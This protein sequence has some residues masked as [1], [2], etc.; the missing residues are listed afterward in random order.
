MVDAAAV[1]D[2]AEAV[3]RRDGAGATIAAIAEASG[4]TK[5]IVYDLVG[6]RTALADALVI[7]LTNRLNE[8]A[9][10]AIHSAE[11]G[12][13]SIVAFLLATLEAIDRDRD[14][15]LYVTAPTGDDGPD[16]RLSLARRASAPIAEQLERQRRAAGL[17]PSAATPW[18][19]AITG[20]VNFVSLW[21]ISEQD[22]TAAEVAEQLADLLW[23]GL[24]GP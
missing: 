14:L 13:P 7:R 10:S 8:A 21:W 12:R 22:R 1:L 18:A 17:D 2:N 9:A 24:G 20:M 23:S 6:G 11:P 3:I 16:R 15:F 19:Y 5:P 4:V